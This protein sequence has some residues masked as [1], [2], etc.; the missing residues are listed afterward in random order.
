MPAF[1]GAE[2]R[3][4]MENEKLPLPIKWERINQPDAFGIASGY[5]HAVYD[6]KEMSA[7]Q[8]IMKIW[9]VSQ[10]AQFKIGHQNILIL[11]DFPEVSSLILNMVDKCKKQCSCSSG[12]FQVP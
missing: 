6:D 5:V 2:L 11:P 10:K 3:T 7:E 8:K 4:Y 12:G 9:E 1:K